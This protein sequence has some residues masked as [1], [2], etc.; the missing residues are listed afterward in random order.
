[1]ARSNQP[2]ARPAVGQRREAESLG[3]NYRAGTQLAAQP[4]RRESQSAAKRNHRAAE[5][6]CAS[7]RKSTALRSRAGRGAE[8]LDANYRA[9]TQLTAQ[10][11]RREAQSAAKRNHRAGGPARS[12]NQLRIDAQSS[13]K[14]NHVH[15]EQLRSG[16]TR[17]AE[18][19][20][21]KPKP[22]V[23]DGVVAPRLA[24]TPRP[25]E[26]REIAMLFRK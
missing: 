16:N 12:G 1:V 14:R 22:R 10:P 26:C 6:S 24:V 3:A 5:I 13:A 17:E 7:R 21:T 4:A 8:S 23:V 20:A 11:A 15:A 9:G 2:A 25:R 19:P 18:S